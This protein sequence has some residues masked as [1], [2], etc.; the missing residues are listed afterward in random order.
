MTKYSILKVEGC[1]DFKR[2]CVKQ[3]GAEYSLGCAGFTVL[4]KTRCGHMM[5]IHGVSQSVSIDIVHS[6]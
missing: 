3:K 2:G 1:V 6:L 4:N 5:C